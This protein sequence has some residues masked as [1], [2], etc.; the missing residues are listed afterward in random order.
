[1]KTRGDTCLPLP[2]LLTREFFARPV[3]TVARDC[4]GK[5]LVS[6][7]DD[8]L[9]VAR[10]V[11]TEAYRGP[12]DQAAHSYRGRRT[13]RTEVMFGP[14][15]HAYVFTLYGIHSA[16][17]IVTGR[18]GQPEAV[19]VR[20]VQ[21]LQGIQHIVARRGAPVKGS[22]L[23]NGPGKLC[24]ALGISRVHDGLD[25]TEGPLTLAW[26]PAVRVTRS[27]RIGIDYAGPWALKPWRFHEPDNPH[28][29][30]RR[31][32]KPRQGNP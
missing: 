18:V 17:N 1:M 24:Q 16:F 29:S 6:R 21:P 25:L 5:L 10:I 22:H 8:S 12:E 14:P 4:I 15:G 2:P 23:T 11:E 7:V 19:L 28:V 26:A 13:P 20:A 31:P 30:K 9:V 3:L 32:T 27:A